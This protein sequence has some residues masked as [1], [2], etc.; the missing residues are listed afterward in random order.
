M[1]VKVIARTVEV[2]LEPSNLSEDMFTLGGRAAGVCYM[3]ED[4]FD[5]KIHNTVTAV[6][7]ANFNIGSGHHSPFD[8]GNITLQ[9]SGIPKIMAMILNST[10]FYTTS[11]KS[12]RYT[13]M[14]PET[15][16]ELNIYNKWV[17]LLDDKIAKIY[18]DIDD[19]SRNKLAMENARYMISVFTPT[20][21]LYTTSFRQLSYL[22]TWLNSLIANLKIRSNKFN[23]RLTPYCEE[24]ANEFYKLTSE[25]VVDNK[26]G[27]F[28]FLV[29]QYG[30]HSIPAEEYFKDQYQTS[31][32]ASFAQLAQAQRHRTIHYEMEFSGE[33]PGEFGCFIPPIIKNTELETEWIGDFYTL[34]PYFPQGTLV[35]VLEQGRVYWFLNKCKERLCGRAQLEIAQQT[36]K[37]MEKIIKHRSELS[38]DMQNELDKCIDNN[39]VCTKCKF[40]EFT[41]KEPCRWGALHGLDRLI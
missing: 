11:E 16:T 37:T 22:T 9:I 25:I 17:A 35:K 29:K 27:K 30:G 32:L 10:E 21:M 4:Y 24:L 5:S 31:Y 26:A 15:E 3:P 39:E 40:K 41:C 20:H 6:K 1:E 18:P 28:Q 14:K 7:R 13:V 12:A 34:A 38:L 23:D 36:A 33:N 19:K 8:H 2:G